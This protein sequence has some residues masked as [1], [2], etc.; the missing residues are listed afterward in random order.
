LLN[1]RGLTSGKGKPFTRERVKML[2]WMY[3]LRSRPERLRAAGYQTA[4]EIATESGVSKGTVHVWRR[5]GLLRA[6]AGTDRG[7]WFYEPLGKDRPREQ[8]G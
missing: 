7:D 4:E 3:S 2:C 5:C 8:Q 6:V 1:A